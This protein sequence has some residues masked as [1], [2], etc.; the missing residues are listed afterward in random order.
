MNEKE[1]L[2]QVINREV[3]NLLG[4]F[5]PAFRMFSSTVSSYLINLI[6]PY[7]DAFINPDGNINTR[8]ANKFLKQEVN[9]KI[10][11]FMKKFEEESSNGKV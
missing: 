3:S 1:L 8:A 4:A 10:D 9:E 6:D 5:N 11:T 2:Y 7:V